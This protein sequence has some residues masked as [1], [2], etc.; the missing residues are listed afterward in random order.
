MKG[1]R[2]SRFVVAKKG[3]EMPSI[4]IEGESK[5]EFVLKDGKIV[6]K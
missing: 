4:A 5:K 6:R 2:P 3:K 1:R